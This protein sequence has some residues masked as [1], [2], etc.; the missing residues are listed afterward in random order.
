MEEQRPRQELEE[1]IIEGGRIE[2]FDTSNSAIFEKEKHHAD[3]GRILAY[4]LVGCLV[5]TW[6]LHYVIVLIL[7][8]KGKHEA[9]ENLSKAFNVWLPMISGLAS[10]V[11]T[12]YFTRE[13]K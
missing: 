12:Y 4:W 2:G 6:V 13:K 7:E 9:A 11:V 10:S 1:K 5:S 3:T 8:W